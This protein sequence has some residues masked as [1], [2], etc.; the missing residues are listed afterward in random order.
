MKFALTKTHGCFDSIYTVLVSTVGKS[1]SAAC[2][3]LSAWLLA[4]AAA[5]ILLQTL[6]QWTASKQTQRA[7]ESVPESALQSVSKMYVPYVWQVEELG[8]AAALCGGV[9]RLL[10]PGTLLHHPHHCSPGPDQC[11]AFLADW[12]L[13]RPWVLQCW[14][15]QPTQLNHC[16]IYRI[17]TNCTSCSICKSRTNNMLM[18]VSCNLVIACTCCTLQVSRLETTPGLRTLANLPVINGLITSFLPSAILRIFLKL[19]PNL[20]GFMSHVQGMTSLSQVDFGV[21][22]KY[23]IFQVWH[24]A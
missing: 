10:C 8:A 13:E 23:F 9:G 20:L 22:R 7:S 11:K 2:V 24:A 19:L 14:T 15:S 18:T 3:N 6:Y 4:L 16:L 12:L 1:S 17:L 21:L 5:V